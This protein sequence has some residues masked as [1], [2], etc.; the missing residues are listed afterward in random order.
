MINAFVMAAA[1]WATAGD[2]A[3]Q[4]NGPAAPQGDWAVAISDQPLG[5]VIA[6][7]EA[8]GLRVYGAPAAPEQ[9]VSGQY[10]GALSTILARLLRSEDYVLSVEDGTLAL[11][12]LSGVVGSAPNSVEER[13]GPV[14]VDANNRAIDDQFDMQQANA[15][16]EVLATLM[17]NRLAQ[18][19][20]VPGQAPSPSAGTGAAGSAAADPERI[21]AMNQ[22]AREQLAGLV[23]ALRAACPEG[24]N[25]D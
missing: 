25:C 8:A 3:L 12:F 20:A 7:L 11:R 10:S 19:S 4:V 23:A 16:A 5:E 18:A 17:A 15:G 22:R 21:R 24:S 2:D 6:E 13:Y 14:R 9:R 1:L